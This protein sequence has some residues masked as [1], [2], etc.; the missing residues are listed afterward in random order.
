LGCPKNLVDTEGIAAGLVEHEI[1]LTS[2]PEE[3]TITLLNTCAFIQDA[4]DETEG[5]IREAIRWKALA[6]R[7]RIVVC[8]CLPS[9]DTNGTW[10]DRYPAVDHWLRKEEY[11]RIPDIITGKPCDDKGGEGKDVADDNPPRLQLT[12]RHYAY[13]RI[14]DGCNNGCSYCTIPAIRGPLRSRRLDAI[15]TEAQELISQGVRELVVIGQDTAS[16]GSDFGKG[17]ESI[18]DLLSELDAIPGRHWIRLM[19]AHPAR[20]DRRLAKR[21]AGARRIVPYLDLPLQHISDE[22]LGAMNRRIT[23][24]EVVE[25]LDRLRATIPALTIRTTFIVGY[26]GETEAHFAEL[27]EFVRERRFERLGAFVYSPEPGTRAFETEGQI[28]RKTALRRLDRLMRLQA[29]ISS[30]LNRALVGREVEVLV[31]SVSGRRAI[32]RTCGDAPDIDNTVSLRW[33]SG[34]RPTA[35]DFVK[36]KVSSSVDYSMVGTIVNEDQDSSYR[37]GA[38]R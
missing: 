20:V 6:P 19:Y 9:W 8:G 3:A 31:D 15:V 27:L 18:D 11:R 33:K 10:R 38:K 7:R 36:I 23:K 5:E 1:A 21:M 2:D 35:G 4:R 26:P 12:P 14:S 29:G 22:I 34:Q 25:L 13:L 16:Y 17:G 32:G 24:N 30:E 28:A 37:A